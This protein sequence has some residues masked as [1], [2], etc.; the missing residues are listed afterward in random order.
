MT[1]RHPP[2][3]IAQ[4]GAPLTRRAML[5]RLAGGAAFAT[6]CAA[7]G[8]LALLGSREPG[9]QAQPAGGNPMSNNQAQPLPRALM[10]LP[11]GA[12]QPNGWL[13]R[14]LR[15]QAD[16][17]TGH[18]GEIFPD[19]GPSS[20]WLGGD[21]EA[22][23]RGPYYVRGLVA[24]AWALD[25]ADLKAAA[26]RW[27]DWTL[28]SL[29]DDGSFGPPQLNP[30]DWWPRM[31]MLHA[32]QWYYDATSDARVI[33]FLSD[34]L[35]FQRARLATQPLFQWATARAA[36]NVM[37]ALWLH[38]RTG[39]DWLLEL[40][41]MLLAQSI[42]WVPVYREHTFANDYWTVHAVNVAEGL[43]NPA[44]RYRLMHNTDYL[45]GLADGLAYLRE[46]NWQVEGLH[47]GDEHLAG[48][49][50][51]RGT[52]TCTVVEMILS[53]Q[54]LL[55]TT[56]NPVYAGMLER[57]ALNALPAL[58]KSDMRAHQYYQTPN[59]VQCVVGDYE[60]Y[61]KHDSRDENTFGVGVGYGCCISNLHM[62]WPRYAAGLWMRTPDDGLAAIGYA[63]C[64]VEAEA[65][66]QRVTVH[67]VT[68]YPF[69]D[70][71]TLLLDMDAPAHFPLMLYIPGWCVAPSV[72]V[73]GRPV[74]AQP[75]TFATIE[76]EWVDGATVELRFPMTVELSHWDQGA[77]S[78]ERGP[79]VY[80]LRVGEE[81]TANHDYGADFHRWEV[82]PTTPWNYALVVNP[83]KPGTSFTLEE[84]TLPDQPWDSDAAPVRLVGEARRVPGWNLTQNVARPLPQSP[85]EEGEAPE[86]VV[87]IPYGA[88]KLRMAVLPWRRT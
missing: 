42:D 50:P 16:G 76:R 9:D 79:L 63:P 72:T 46:A 84:D 80:A 65:G 70:R 2:P 73:N 1:K 17:L 53:L 6:V 13:Q 3:D 10:P 78:V 69:D 35:D 19:V 40:A 87:L 56:A 15:L 82:R 44:M 48:T 22:W 67:E 29:R 26:R 61:T 33:P 62:G 83:D 81:W 51:T 74:E 58:F 14:Q 59:Q 47:S 38:E 45:D 34:Y 30:V 7:T 37:T 24:L 88:A 20:A 60:W 86:R 27:I 28:D 8:T 41:E 18:T 39:G 5:A 75:G 31:P 57:V 68:D 21:G 52:E 23:E 77:V 32:L 66:G 25:D 71:V 4:P 36:D 49:D 11:L 55:E 54:T 85:V 12:V 43:R 64:T